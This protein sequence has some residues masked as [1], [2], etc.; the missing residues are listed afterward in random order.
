MHVVSQKKCDGEAVS[1]VILSND[2]DDL[3]QAVQ[4]KCFDG[5]TRLT[6][7]INQDEWN[8]GLVAIVD[9]V[10]KVFDVDFWLAFDKQQVDAVRKTIHF[11]TE[12][13]PQMQLLIPILI[14]ANLLPALLS[15]TLES[16]PA[17]LEAAQEWYT[18]QDCMDEVSAN[19][20]RR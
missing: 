6:I 3:V 17:E 13:S 2:A 19:Y 14:Q 18:E 5:S 20:L 10:K 11:A 7:T 15:T 16:I 8:D 1:I 12:Y 9:A 4:Y